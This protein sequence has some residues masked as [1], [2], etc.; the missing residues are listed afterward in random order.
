VVGD[1]ANTGQFGIGVVEQPSG[2][3]KLKNIKATGT[4]DF[5]FAY[6]APGDQ[7]VA[8]DWD[9]NGTWTPGV[10]ED[11][12]AGALVWKLRNSNSSGPPD[13]APFNYGANTFVALVG[14]PDFPTQPQFAFGGEGPGAAAISAADLSGALQG[15]LAR[16]QQAGVSADTL[17]RLAGVTAV[18][19]PLTPGQLG[20]AALHGTT[21]QLSPDGAGHGWFVDSTPLQDEEFVGGVAYAGSPA[22]GREDLLTTVL[23]ELGHIAGLSDN[24]GSTLMTDTLAEGTR[25]LGALD[26]A[27]AATT[28]VVVLPPPILPPKGARV[29]G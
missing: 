7:V 19:T 21:I 29:G 25:Q 27:F 5:V 13:I 14:D 22:A 12:G 15:A 10:V 23:H 18:L 1:W 11:N 17:G 24:D 20:A 6:G 16:L 26:A 28:P 8:G 3:W 2:I 4:P 9:G